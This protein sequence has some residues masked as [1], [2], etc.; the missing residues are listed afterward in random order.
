MLRIAGMGEVEVVSD[1]GFDGEV[2]LRIEIGVGGG[3]APS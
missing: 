3:E 2:G 1:V